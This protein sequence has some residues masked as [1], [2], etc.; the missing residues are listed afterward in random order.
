MNLIALVHQSIVQHGP[1]YKDAMLQHDKLLIV[2]AIVCSWIAI[3]A[4]VV[5]Y[6]ITK[7]AKRKDDDGRWL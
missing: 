2:L 7:W 6:N 4:G 1:L 3:A 5:A